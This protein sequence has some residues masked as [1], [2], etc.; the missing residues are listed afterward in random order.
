MLRLFAVGF[1][2]GFQNNS[3][4]ESDGRGR[5]AVFGD[6]LNR[7]NNKEKVYEITDFGKKFIG[8]LF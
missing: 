8:I 6:S 2:N 7:V 1:L 5:I 3:P 4:F